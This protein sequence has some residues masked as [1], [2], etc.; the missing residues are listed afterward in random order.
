MD[1]RVDFPHPVWP[2]TIMTLYFSTHHSSLSRCLYIGKRCLCASRDRL[3]C[4]LDV[5]TKDPSVSVARS[6]ELPVNDQRPVFRLEVE[7]Y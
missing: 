5:D 6:T 2:T 7:V 3:A 4:L 1:V